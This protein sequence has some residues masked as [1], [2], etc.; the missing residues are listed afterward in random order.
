MFALY[1]II[2][3]LKGSGAM[4]VLTNALLLGNAASIVLPSALNGWFH[5]FI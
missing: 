4:A 3:P 5:W 1:A 2:D